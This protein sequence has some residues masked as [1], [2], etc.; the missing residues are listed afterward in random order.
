MAVDTTEVT[1]VNGTDTTAH[2]DD[3]APNTEKATREKVDLTKLAADERVTLMITLPAG[4]KIALIEAG[5]KQGIAAS[6]FARNILSERL[7]YAVPASFTERSRSSKWA[8]EEEKKAHYA[9][10]AKKR[11]DFAKQLVAAA[12]AGDMELFARLSEEAKNI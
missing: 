9:N 3:D 5:E 4:M 10:A 8:S 12:K 11:A 7:E 1:N 6:A 2:E